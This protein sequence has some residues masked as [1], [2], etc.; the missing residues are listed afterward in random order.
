MNI[1]VEFENEELVIRVP[2]DFVYATLVYNPDSSLVTEEDY[3]DFSDNC[4]LEDFEEFSVDLLNEIRR[5]DETGWSLVNNL[6]YKAGEE[7]IEQGARG[8]K[9][10]EEEL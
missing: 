8:I 5:E 6:I 1:S 3:E 7:A 10:P 2:K 4:I 9:F